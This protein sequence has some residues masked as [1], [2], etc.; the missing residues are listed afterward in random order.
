MRQQR[1][2]PMQ[3]LARRVPERL[4][5]QKKTPRLGPVRSEQLALEL[6][7][8]LPSLLPERV[9]SPE[10]QPCPVERV[11][12]WQQQEPPRPVGPAQLRPGAVAQSPV[13]REA[14]SQS[15]GPVAEPQYSRPDAATE[16]SGVEPVP[17]KQSPP[18]LPKKPLAWAHWS[19]QP[20]RAAPEPPPS[21]QEVAARHS[22]AEG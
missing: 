18:V 20:P 17:P 9:E 16:Q 10:G 11:R 19:A 5:P 1:P 4:E 22:T 7:E 6:A 2:E 3:T 21:S 12:H 13:Q 15:P 8:G 14:G